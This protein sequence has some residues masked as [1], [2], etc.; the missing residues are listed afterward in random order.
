MRKVLLTLFALLLFAVNAN[1]QVYGRASKALSLED[2]S[3]VGIIWEPTGTVN[4]TEIEG[5]PSYGLVV[6]ITT[7][8]QYLDVEPGNKIS[9]EFT[10]DTREVCEIGVTDK[11]YN[12]MVSSGRVV[13]M[14]SRNM[15]IHPNFDNMTS[16]QIKRIVIQRDNGNVWIINTKPKRAKKLV[17]EFQN[18]MKEAK[19]DYQ[20]RVTNEDYFK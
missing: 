15:L 5:N 10:D 11:S 19:A 1:S 4:Y 3:F 20:T 16:K 6:V 8:N 18:A 12:N 14:F 2:N 9:I 7:S 13:E 17:S